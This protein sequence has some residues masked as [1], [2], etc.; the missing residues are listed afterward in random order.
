VRSARGETHEASRDFEFLVFR[1]QPF[2]FDA[3]HPTGPEPARRMHRRAALDRVPDHRNRLHR[4]A[5]KNADQRTDG[6]GRHAA[7]LVCRLADQVTE[8][9]IQLLLV[10]DLQ[11]MRG[12]LHLFGFARPVIRSLQRALACTELTA[13][14]LA[15]IHPLVVVH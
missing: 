6:V 9:A 2:Q 7:D 10:V 1:A 3:E 8:E 4:G 13:S 5:P 12:Q 14:N 15:G 11:Q